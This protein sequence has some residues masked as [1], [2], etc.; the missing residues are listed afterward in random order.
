VGDDVVRGW[1]SL[2][3]LDAIDLGEELGM[4]WNDEAE[5]RGAVV[6]EGFGDVDRR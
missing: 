3:A 4:M 6:R 2:A 5:R 1:A